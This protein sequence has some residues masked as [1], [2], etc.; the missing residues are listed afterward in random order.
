MRKKLVLLIGVL[1]MIGLL[2]AA[3]S[4]MAGGWATVTL[5]ELPEAVVAERPFTIEFSVRGH[6]QTL[7]A[8]LDA[9]V[10]AVHAVSGTRVHVQAK[11]SA[12]EGFYT[13]TLALPE[14]GQWRWEISTYG[15]AYPMPP[16]MAN[17]AA[18]AASGVSVGG[19][20]VGATPVAW[21]L[22][23]GWTAAVGAALCLFFWTRQRSQVRLA[24]VVLLG[25]VSLASFALHTQMA[26][27][28]L[29][30]SET[31]LLPAIDPDVMGEA[32]FVAKG[33]IQCHTNDNVTIA[34]NMFEVG[35][36]LT[37]VKRPPEYVALWLAN[38]ANLKADTLMPNLHLSEAEIYMLVDFL[39]Q[40]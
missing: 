17:Q 24:G 31:T 11:D 7:V 21:Q 33:C 8:G 12:E 40:D 14:A 29:A 19:T 20:A 30:E 36:D 3:G 32:L 1:L 22:I 34:S 25:V 6:G 13:A 28:V 9:A 26:Q 27:P 10:T 38:P 23:L 2:A 16:L 15:G 35:P 4:V 37:F 18:V 39:Y 5:S